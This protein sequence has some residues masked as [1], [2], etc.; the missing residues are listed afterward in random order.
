MRVV[1]VNELTNSEDRVHFPKTDSLRRGEEVLGMLIDT[2]PVPEPTQGSGKET[3][4]DGK[5]VEDE[6][7]L[8]YSRTAGLWFAVKLDRG[9]V[10]EGSY[11]AMHIQHSIIRLTGNNYAI[12]KR[13]ATSEPE[14]VAKP[15]DLKNQWNLKSRDEVVKKRRKNQAITNVSLADLDEPQ[16][17]WLTSIPVSNQCSQ[18]QKIHDENPKNVVTE[19]ITSKSLA[20]PIHIDAQQLKDNHVK[21]QVNTSDSYKNITKTLKV[22]FYTYHIRQKKIKA[23]K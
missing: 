17:K 22:Y 12:S 2:K 11:A 20:L 7:P 8:V 16:G 18:L 6:K 3:D 23:T 14:I 10:E 13:Q 1:D 4:I 15:M 21:V 5:A 19:K 9:G